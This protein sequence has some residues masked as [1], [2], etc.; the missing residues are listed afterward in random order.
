MEDNRIEQIKCNKCNGLFLETEIIEIM[1]KP[2]YAGGKAWPESVSP[3][4][5]SRFMYNETYVIKWVK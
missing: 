3:C 4:C 5:N 2:E 1:G